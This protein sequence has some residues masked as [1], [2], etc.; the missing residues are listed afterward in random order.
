ML[1]TGCEF[2]VG[3]GLDKT[4]VKPT[5]CSPIAHSDVAIT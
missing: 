3:V 1:C 2:V 5:A 4:R